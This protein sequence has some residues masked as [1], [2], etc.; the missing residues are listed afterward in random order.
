M[1]VYIYIYIYIYYHLHIDNYLGFSCVRCCC[2]VAQYSS[3]RRVCF[4]DGFLDDLF[5]RSLDRS[6][7]LVAECS[8]YS[9]RILCSVPRLQL[10]SLPSAGSVPIVSRGVLHSRQCALRAQP[11]IICVGSLRLRRLSCGTGAYFLGHP[12]RSAHRET[13]GQTSVASPS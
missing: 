5:G 1:Y 6:A 13:L 2:F 4:M 8:S 7:R 11:H 9:E 3:L 12:P 10:P